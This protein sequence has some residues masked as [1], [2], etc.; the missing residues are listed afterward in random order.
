MALSDEV[1]SF[2]TTAL[3]SMSS[4]TAPSEASVQDVEE[5]CESLSMHTAH[6]VADEATFQVALQNITDR[7]MAVKLAALSMQKRHELLVEWARAGLYESLSGEACPIEN[8]A[9]RVRSVALVLG[10]AQERDALVQLFYSLL[11]RINLSVRSVTV[12]S[13]DPSRSCETTRTR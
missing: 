11:S 13:P 12:P 3:S 10:T 2:E 1:M 5:L 4:A 7:L 8:E 9:Q 6:A